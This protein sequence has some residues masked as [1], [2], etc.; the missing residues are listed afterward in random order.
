MNIISFVGEQE[1]FFNGALVDDAVSWQKEKQFAIQ[2]FQAN[3]YLSKVATQNPPSAQNALINV[4]A[5]GVTLNP[6]SK[7]A[8]LVP[9][10]GSVYLDISYIGLLHL[11]QSTGSILWGQAK[12]VYENDTYENVG[13]DKSPM[14]KTNPFGNRGEPIGVYC[15]VKTATGDYLTDEMSRADVESIRDRSESWKR[16]QSGPW[17]TDP[18][19]MWRKTVVKRASKYW[20]KV[21]RLDKAIDFLNTE[22]EEGFTNN[23]REIEINPSQTIESVLHSKGRSVEQFLPWASKVVKREIKSTEDLTDYEKS[24]FISKLEAR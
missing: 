12:V 21:E 22:G 14:H 10:K 16:S 20:P 23:H 1:E 6:A 15:V 3:E 8:Y 17:K 4:A 9:R 24:E 5:I 13:V 11:A 18:L 2:A 19:E 7:M